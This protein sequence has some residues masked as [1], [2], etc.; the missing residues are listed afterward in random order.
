MSTTERIPL[1]EPNLR[2][3]EA[4]YL[5]RCLESGWI[6]SIGPFVAEFEKHLGEFVG[7]PF[8]LSTGTGTVA[9]H[10]ALAALRIGPGDEVIVPDLTFAASANAVLYCG[11][12][13]VLVDVRPSDWGM[14]PDAVRRAIT[15]RTK[16]IM[17][18]HLYGHPC[19]M[20]P[21][22]AIAR[23]HGLYVV[24]DAAEALGAR[25]QGAQVGSFGDIACFSFYAN[26]L[27]TTGE[28]GACVTARRDLHE[29]MAFLRDHG[30]SKQRRYWHEE[31]GFN[32]RMTS[33]QAAIG[34]A[35]M[36]RIGELIAL[37]RRNARLYR[38]HLGDLGVALSGE[39]SWATSAFW[40]F[41]IVLPAEVDRA[42][43]MA[44]LARQG[45]DSRCV[46]YPLHQMPPYRELGAPGETFA[47]ADELG[48]RGLSLPSATT[49]TEAQIETVC[50]AVRGFLGESAW[51][52]KT[53]EPITTA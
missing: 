34:L 45:I 12:K 48:G 22:M 33:L 42:E 41:N 9:L 35:Q 4:S 43:T 24:E 14:D 40:M 39:Q 20:E 10:L 49:L 2:G 18:V 30:M 28:G 31:V 26:K 52:T 29:R 47:C 7:Q 15:P 36:E 38:H 19:E 46:F 6:S 11:A 17:P 50:R 25:Y 16:A 27:I 21:L 13:P 3:N 53:F 51:A 8:C 5:Q 23:A 37:K 44:A 1:A 32:Y